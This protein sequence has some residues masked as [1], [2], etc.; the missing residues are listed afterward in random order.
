MNEDIE[1]IQRAKEKDETA[2][3][4][5]FSKYKPLASKIS[6]RYF[7]IGQDQDDLEQ[8]AMIGLFRAFQSFDANK[9]SDFG[10]FASM[11]ISRQ[12]QSAI[13]LANREKNKA[14]N[15][16]IGLNNQGGFTLPMKDDDEE[17][18]L[19]VVPS[20]TPL[21]DDEL[22]SKQQV[23][24]MTSEIV[25]NLSDYE[26]KVLTLYLKGLK[27][28]EMS[29]ALGKDIKSVENSLTRIKNKLKFLKTL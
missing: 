16:S 2:F 19:F 25:K 29:I 12:I 20:L 28:K 13:K 9:N 11:C 18:I 4:K 6:R 8:E 27:Y 17:V 7:L 3:E 23:S 10:S 1:L 14:L 15:E 24:Q 26:K 21:P 5:L 22:I